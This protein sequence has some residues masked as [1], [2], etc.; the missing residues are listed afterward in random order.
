MSNWTTIPQYEE[1]SDGEL[2]LNNFLSNL[3][4]S[5]SGTELKESESQKFDTEIM[6]KGC[7]SIPAEEII[8]IGCATTTKPQKI[9]CTTVA[10]PTKMKVKKIKS[11]EINKQLNHGNWLGYIIAV[12]IN[13]TI[14]QSTECCPGC[15]DSKN[16][17]LFHS[18]HH[19]GLLEKLYMFA[20]SVRAMLISKLPVLVADYISKYPD[21]EIYDDT[22]KKVLANIGRTFIRQCNP[23]FVYY[24][25]YL[26]PVVDEVVTTTPILKS[27]PMTLKRVAN[28]AYKGTDISKKMKTQ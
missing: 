14:T 28:S 4:S 13:E 22:G 12:F 19:S 24:S 15:K 25:K 2:W 17:P 16:S 7:T 26:T 10:K 23:T 8:K 27:Q 21:L 11:T 20:P 3:N 1:D 18:H 6:K 5:T 9:G